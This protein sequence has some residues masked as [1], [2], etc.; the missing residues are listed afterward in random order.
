MHEVVIPLN[1]EA[2]MPM[3][4]QAE[5]CYKM[6]HDEYAR[7]YL[8]HL[9]IRSTAANKAALKHCSPLKDKDC[10]VSGIWAEHSLEGGMAKA[11]KITA[12]LRHRVGGEAE[13]GD[14][15]LR[16]WLTPVE[17]I[18]V[19]PPAVWRSGINLY[20]E[21]SEAGP[22]VMHGASASNALAVQA[23]LGNARAGT[24]LQ[25]ELDKVRSRSG[26]K[27]S[28]SLTREAANRGGA[29]TSGKLDQ[30]RKERYASEL[31]KLK[32]KF[33]FPFAC[34][35]PASQPGRV[36]ISP[37]SSQGPV[38]MMVPGKFM[39]EMMEPISVSLDEV[40]KLLAKW[41]DEH[42]PL[43][44]L[45]LRS[46]PEVFDRLRGLLR[47]PDVARLIG[48]LAHLLYWL[49]FGCLRRDPAERL[50]QATLQS[51]QKA[52][53]DMWLA[54]EKIHRTTSL[55]VS[56]GLPCLLLTIKRGIERCFEL[57]Y[58]RLMADEMLRSQLLKQL[59]TVCMRL[60]DPSCVYARFGKFD[61]TAKAIILTKQLE[62]MA[63]G[64]GKPKSERLWGSMQMQG[65][66]RDAVSGGSKAGTTAAPRP[67]PPPPPPLAPR[68]P[69]RPPSGIA[70]SSA[71]DSTS[72]G[73]AQRPGTLPRL[74]S[75]RSA[76]DSR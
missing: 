69:S 52:V 1:H 41:V 72:G 37:W 14:A 26:L 51:L 17:P 65:T 13:D 27:C 76:Q 55:G 57:Q 35:L 15:L 45:T 16:H 44:M 43:E 9:G 64:D 21:E 31:S 59:N 18:N 36:R 4:L 29:A 8:D 60:L 48:M 38:D 11:V 54:M 74:S 19:E 61:G 75:A 68:V 58:K 6:L 42:M 49:V 53:M 20:D 67:Q 7:R 66:P 23:V 39:P 71:R 30:D 63:L 3:T 40:H 70:C 10:V 28:S 5:D 50:S 12:P 33:I 32:A 46:E 62:V 24:E 22:S 56:L 34:E 2:G 73:R 47:A 25:A